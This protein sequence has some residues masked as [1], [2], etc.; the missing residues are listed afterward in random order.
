HLTFK[1]P[2]LE[3]ALEEARRAGFTPVGIYLDDPDWKE[4]FLHPKQACGIVVQLAQPSGTWVDM[5]PIGGLPQAKRA[6]AELVR[7]T[8]LVP[9]LERAV[10]LFGDLLGGDVQRDGDRSAL[11]AWTGPGRVRLLQPDAGSE[12]AAWL[13][14]RPGR[15]RDLTFAADDPATIPNAV[16]G[17]V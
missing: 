14:D 5:P 1:T 9:D 3:A 4:A 10:A 6:N 7:V 15:V 17:D 8:H 2:D 16:A 11:V 12:D 13:G